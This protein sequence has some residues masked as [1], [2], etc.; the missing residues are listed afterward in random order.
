MKIFTVAILFI[1]TTVSCSKGIWGTGNSYRPKKPNFSI[2]KKGFTGNELVDTNYMYI[3]TKEFKNFD[4][5]VI[6][7]YM[8]FY[9]DGRFIIGSST[10]NELPSEMLK[11]NSWQTASAVGYYTTYSQK[12]KTEFFTSDGGGEYVRR[13][14]IIKK[15]TII[16]QE[17]FTLLGRK[18]IRSD[19]LIKSGYKVE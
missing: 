18:E 9:Q 16:F 6:I 1:I 19:T 2:L 4:G 8:G 13:E 5:N 12:I 15:D 3:S 7:G 14:G 11:K 17:T 10:K